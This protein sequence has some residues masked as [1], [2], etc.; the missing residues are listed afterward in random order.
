MRN[1]QTYVHNLP[2]FSG[3]LIFISQKK[4]TKNAGR[5]DFL[6]KYAS[7]IGA[8]SVHDRYVHTSTCIRRS[9]VLRTNRFVSQVLDF[10]VEV[11]GF[12]DE[13]RHVGRHAGVEVRR[14]DF[15]G[16]AADRVHAARTRVALLVVRVGVGV[17]IR[18]RTRTRLVTAVRDAFGHLIAAELRFLL[19]DCRR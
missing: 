7:K 15:G 1:T 16:G 10:T 11:G 6:E 19:D 5:R 4:Y 9:Y 13:R 2:H 12:A 18:V 17:R 8:G 3:R 14:T